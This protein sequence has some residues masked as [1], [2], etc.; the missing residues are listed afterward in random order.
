MLE[1]ETAQLSH[2]NRMHP[3]CVSAA[4]Y[5]SSVVRPAELAA[6]KNALYQQQLTEASLPRQS[7][8]LMA[9]LAGSTYIC[10]AQCTKRLLLTSLLLR[11]SRCQSATPTCAI[12]LVHELEDVRCHSQLLYQQTS[13]VNSIPNCNIL[14]VQPVLVASM[15]KLLCEPPAPLFDSTE[16]ASASSQAPHD[17]EGKTPASK[18]AVASSGPPQIHCIS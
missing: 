6:G 10:P 4:A 1:M 14:Q 17:R 9:M 16:Q 2:S 18:N 7:Q 5:H 13:T 3:V 8:S 15:T 12:H 11:I